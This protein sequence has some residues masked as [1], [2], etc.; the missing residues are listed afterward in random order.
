MHGF[1]FWCSGIPFITMVAKGGLRIRCET[2]LVH[3]IITDRFHSPKPEKI[4]NSVDGVWIL[5]FLAS[6]LGDFSYCIWG[7][8]TEFNQLGKA[9]KCNYSA[10]FPTPCGLL[11]NS[12]GALVKAFPGKSSTTDPYVAT[13]LCGVTVTL[14]R[15]RTEWVRAPVWSQTLVFHPGP[16]TS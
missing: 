7:P 11:I 12:D 5:A 6:T 8:L 10:I 2:S 1:R 3:E 15:W 16:T 13:L 4:Q 9:G 14:H